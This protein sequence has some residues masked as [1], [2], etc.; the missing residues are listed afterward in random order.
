M[1]VAW[2]KIV[3]NVNWTLLLGVANFGILLYLLKRLL[4]RPALEFLDRRREQIAERIHVAQVSE[5]RAL[6]LVEQRDRELQTARERMDQL[7]NDAR[8]EAD[9]MLAEARSEARAD[10]V[11]ILADGRRQLEQERDR[12]IQDLKNAYAQ[13]AV[14]GA[15]RVL[16][17][18]IRSE[19]H[20]RLLDQLLEELDDE[21]LRIGS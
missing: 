10:S 5:Q 2:G 12:M 14:L 9:R 4:F 7:L 13:M 21:A 8:Q 17:R 1:S 18:E 16:D 3:E 19:D 11:R 20:R 6:A 15:E